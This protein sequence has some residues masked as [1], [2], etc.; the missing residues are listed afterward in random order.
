MIEARIA[1]MINA[2]RD[3]IVALSKYNKLR[4]RFKSDLVLVF[5]GNEDPI[6]YTIAAQRSGTKHQFKS[7]VAN[8]KD[9][10]LGL[11]KL[12]SESIEVEKGDG[13][14]FLVD[15]DFDG[16]KHYSPGK[17][18]YVTPTYSIEN[19][20]CSVTALQHLLELEFKLHSHDYQ[21]DIEKI[22][23]IYSNVFKTFY[24][25]MKDVN[26]LIYFGRTKSMEMLGSRISSIDDKNASFFKF[27]KNTLA[28]SCQCK[29][30]EVKKFIKFD[31]DFDL[32]EAQSVL[33]EFNNLDPQTK[34]RGKFHF[35]LFIQLVQA[36]VEDRNL[37]T[38]KY[39]SQ[40]KGNVKLNFSSDSAFRILSTACEIPTCLTEFLRN[41]P[42]N[43]MR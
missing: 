22:T 38:P 15:A 14:A 29:G 7:F 23:E 41:L 18:V 9:M 27:D 2:T 28:V 37:R 31:I 4:T 34:W 1:K 13:V 3:P 33:D 30:N 42:A 25:E 32:N 8:G 20:V 24:S 12:I 17:D 26:L 5:E 40:G 6:F 10:V 39:F 11:R 36:L 21:Q 19:I 43:A 16:I 35:E